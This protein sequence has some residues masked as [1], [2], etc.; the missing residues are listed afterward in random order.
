[1]ADLLEPHLWAALIGLEHE[2]ADELAHAC[3]L[4]TFG[5]LENKPGSEALLREYNA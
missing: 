5:A 1:M 4:D 2:R 3:I